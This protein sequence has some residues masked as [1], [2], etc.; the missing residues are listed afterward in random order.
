MDSTIFQPQ[1]TNLQAQLQQLQ[2]LMAQKPAI[3]QTVPAPPRTMDFVD[4]EAGAREFLAGL[5]PNSNA[6]AFDRNESCFFWC[7]KDANGTPAPLRRCPFTVEEVPEPGTDTITRKDFD[8]FKDEI[9]SALAALAPKE[10][11][12]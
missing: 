5:G 1:I 8:A 4:G 9:R 11:E 7:S 2:S 10:A 12:I 3:P 6:A